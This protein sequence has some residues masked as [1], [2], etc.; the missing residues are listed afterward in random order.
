[1]ATNGVAAGA[2]FEGESDYGREMNKSVD[3]P[4]ASTHL[5]MSSTVQCAVAHWSSDGDI[6]LARGVIGLLWCSNPPVSVDA[7]GK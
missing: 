2:A 7:N 6:G 1:V 5:E 3:P 4:P